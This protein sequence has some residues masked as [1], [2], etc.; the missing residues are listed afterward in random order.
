MQEEWE[1]IPLKVREMMIA[2]TKIQD[3]TDCGG[4]DR[5]TDYGIDVFVNHYY[6]SGDDF[7][8]DGGFI[9]KQCTLGKKGTTS[10]E[11]YTAWHDALRLNDT[12]YTLWEKIYSPIKVTTIEQNGETFII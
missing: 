10:E 12:D 6:E 7:L 3:E 9:W 5:F 1:K 2:E 8:L 11:Y 4:Q